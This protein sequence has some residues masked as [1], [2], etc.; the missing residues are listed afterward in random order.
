MFLKRQIRREMD[1]VYERLTS[2]LS[3][4]NEEGRNSPKC[5]LPQL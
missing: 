2:N 5:L 1:R 4:N 3:R